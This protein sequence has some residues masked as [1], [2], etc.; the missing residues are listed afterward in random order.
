MVN[1]I[2]SFNHWERDRT[3]ALLQV[4]VY[5][6]SEGI[7]RVLDVRSEI[8]VNLFVLGMHTLEESLDTRAHFFTTISVHFR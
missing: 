3:E 5:I 1:S 4:T 7:E 2:E 8:L 6:S